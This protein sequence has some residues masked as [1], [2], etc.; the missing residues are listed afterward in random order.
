MSGRSS[1]PRALT[2]STGATGSQGIQGIQ[3]VPGIQ[4]VAGET[5][6][7][8]PT[9]E[10]GDP[11]EPGGSLLTAF[12]TYATNTTAPPSGGQART[13]SPITTLW[14][15]E[16][17]TDG[18]VRSFGLGT[19]EVGDTIIVRAANG[20]AMD[21]LITGTPTDAGTYWSFPVSVTSGTVTKGARTQFG[22]LSPTPHGLPAGGSTGQALTKTSGADY[23]AG[24]TSVQPL[25]ADLTQIAAL[26][27]SGDSVLEY[28][29][30]AW[31]DRP[32]AV[33]KVDLSLNK[34]D[35]GLGNVDNTPDATNR[36]PP[37]RPTA[38]DAKAPIRRTLNAQTGTT[39]TPVVAD[40]NTMVTL[41]N[42]AAIT[43]TLPS[44]ATQPIPI[45][46]ETDYLWLGVGQPSFAAGSGATVNATPGL[47]LRARYSAA[48]A[49]KIATN[50]WVII[51]DLSA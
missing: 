32:L 25:D 17:D 40:E 7:T 6:S 48:T 9:G 50:D 44:N 29:T 10:K 12:W 37:P 30:G 28:N 13:N 43:V 36:S 20:T 23:A 5:G 16:T 27:P 33:F 49:K 41:S 24:W 18:M 2:G 1:G 8:G 47:K 14:L 15:S 46:A 3:G 31:I 42:A 21:L 4:G 26:A 51:G 39:Y 19:A 11:G 38:L 35:V 22:I 45:G 34:T